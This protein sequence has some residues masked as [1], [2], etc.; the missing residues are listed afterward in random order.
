M[1]TP[2]DVAG[3]GVVFIGF[4][5]TIFRLNPNRVNIIFMRMNK[6]IMAKLHHQLKH[7]SQAPQMPRHDVLMNNWAGSSVLL[8]IIL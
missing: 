3:A 7:L 8:G 2:S 5:T 6:G 4:T 1:T